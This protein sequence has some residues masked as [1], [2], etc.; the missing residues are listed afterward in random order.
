MTKRQKIKHIYKKVEPTQTIDE[1]E[2]ITFP[3]PKKHKKEKSKIK[4]K[5][6]A[7]IAMLKATSQNE[8]KQM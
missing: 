6:E 4:R 5:R 1:D 3:T 7:V 8:E 2:E